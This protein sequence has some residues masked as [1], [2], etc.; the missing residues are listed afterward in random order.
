MCVDEYGPVLA[1]FIKLEKMLSETLIFVTFIS[2]KAHQNPPKKPD[3]ICRPHGPQVTYLKHNSTSDNLSTWRPGRRSGTGSTAGGVQ[4]LVTQTWCGSWPGTTGHGQLH[5]EHGPTQDVWP[6]V[7]TTPDPGLR[8]FKA[9][10]GHLSQPRSP[11]GQQG[12]DYTGP[13]TQG[14][15]DLPVSPRLA[16]WCPGAWRG[17]RLPGRWWTGP[18][19]PGVGR[20]AHVKHNPKQ[21]TSRGRR[22]L[23]SLEIRGQGGRGWS[24]GGLLTEGAACWATACCEGQP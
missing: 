8:C 6:R 24:V 9:P 4:R 18:C 22:A 16:R 19:C 13:S 7:F 17:W 12:R 10:A 15:H 23:D 21:E 5:Q 1:K 20:K 11:R 3:N 14:R 2:I